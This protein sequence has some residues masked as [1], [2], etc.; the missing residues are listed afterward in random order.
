MWCL[1]ELPSGV[2]VRRGWLSQ[3]DQPTFDAFL[4]PL[5][6]LEWP[7][8]AVLSDTPKGLV[9]AVA[10]V[11]PHSRHQ[12]CPAHYLRHLAAPLAEADAAFQRERRKPVREQGGDLIRQAPRTA[13]GPAGVLTVTGRLP[14][15][16]APPTAPAAPH[17]T[18]RDTPPVPEAE[19]DAGIPQCVRHTRYLLTLKGRPPFRLAGIE[20]SERR[21]HVAPCSLDLLAER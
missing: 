19:A 8:L 2:T 20:T 1:R 12:C 21:Q 14:S 11:W 17:S 5:Q 3:Q 7:M 18:R 16:L 13:P 15:P 9:P 6:H 4:Q 10:T